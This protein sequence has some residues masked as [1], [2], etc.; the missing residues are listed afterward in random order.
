MI[1]DEN[2]RIEIQNITL[3]LATLMLLVAAAM[4][5]FGVHGDWAKYLYSLGALLAQALDSAGEF[6]Q[7]ASGQ[8]YDALRAP[9]AAFTYSSALRADVLAAWLN[10]SCGESEPARWFILSLDGDTVRLYLV[11]DTAQVCGTTLSAQAFTSALE[12]YIVARAPWWQRILLATGGL[13][14]IDPTWQTDLIGLAVIAVVVVI[15]I[16]TRKNGRNTPAVP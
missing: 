3:A 12:G 1:T 2:K 6:Q 5:I 16:A 7:A 8:V 9:S 4:P 14:L 15:Q 13:S 11:G 10:A